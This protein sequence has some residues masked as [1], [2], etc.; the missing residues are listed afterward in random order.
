[1]AGQELGTPSKEEVMVD[2]RVLSSCLHFTLPLAQSS[3]Y[4]AIVEGLIISR[5][6]RAVPLFETDF[7]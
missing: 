7:P 3:I 2:Y 1:M 4:Y 5:D 6:Y